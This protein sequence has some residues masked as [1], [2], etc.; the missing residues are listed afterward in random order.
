MDIEF[1]I[2]AGMHLFYVFSCLRVKLCAKFHWVVA[3]V[4][5]HKLLIRA[6]E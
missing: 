3:S 4:G 6:G 2:E 5:K 1:Y